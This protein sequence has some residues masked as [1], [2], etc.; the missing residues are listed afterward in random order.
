MKRVFIL[1]VVA[2]LSNSA[3]E[4]LRSR[5]F[6]GSGNFSYYPVKD[7]FTIGDTLWM[8]FKIPKE[9]SN[10]S[11]DLYMEIDTLP[12]I[13]S[14][15]ISEVLNESDTVGSGTNIY[16]DEMIMKYGRLDE[17]HIF[18]KDENCYL[19]EFGYILKKAGLFFISA[20][21]FKYDNTFIDLY[22]IPGLGPHCDDNCSRTG[23][24]RFYSTFTETGKGWF[25]IV[26]DE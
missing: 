18:I 24:G 17:K 26:V 3:C 14:L 6:Y 13:L 21:N 8:S 22:D 5:D 16:P 15:Y 20:I 7:T 23:G 25:Q 12:T 11:F 10:E 2:G 4:D 9:L 1:I 19:F